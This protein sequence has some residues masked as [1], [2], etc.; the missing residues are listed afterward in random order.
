MKRGVTFW[1]LSRVAV[2]L[3]LYSI[4]NLAV[5]ELVKRKLIWEASVQFRESG[6]TMEDLYDTFMI[7]YQQQSMTIILIG[8]ALS[9]PW[10]AVMYHRDTM[11][12]RNIG[13]ILGVFSDASDWDGPYGRRRPLS[14]KI[15]G[16]T[17]IGSMAL[18][19][20]LNNLIALTPLIFWSKRY[21]E[22]SEF[23]YADNI[24]MEFAAV[25]LGAAVAE[26]LLMRGLV[27]GRLRE[28]MSVRAAIFFS[29]LIFGISHGNIVQGLYAFLMG[30]FLAWLY[31]RFGTLW[32][33]I[34][35]HMSANVFSVCLTE[36]PVLDELL[37]GFQGFLAGNIFCIVLAVGMFHVL[38]SEPEKDFLTK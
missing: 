2:P 9:V 21:A 18:A 1:G 13:Q 22:V 15:V 37:S 12:R 10:L 8:V 31:E 25:G 34:L 38:R 30:I 6:M 3:I 17:A 16:W 28:M 20:L 11:R 14:L 23:L 7:R 29:A 33:A 27:Y 24:W 32:I 19:L 26:E 5:A 35:A 4:F 36:I